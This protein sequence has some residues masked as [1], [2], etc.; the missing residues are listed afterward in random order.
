MNNF[1]HGLNISETESTCW[2]HRE[3]FLATCPTR[4]I[5]PGWAPGIFPDPGFCDAPVPI[6]GRRP[7][8]SQPTWPRPGPP[9]ET[10]AGRPAGWRHGLATLPTPC[11]PGASRRGGP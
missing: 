11:Q 2:I 10:Q 4:S 8:R 7:G 5:Q 3:M 6:P 1:A 9:G